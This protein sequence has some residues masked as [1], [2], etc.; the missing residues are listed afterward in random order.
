[1]GLDTAIAT[2]RLASAGIPANMD[3]TVKG[4]AETSGTEA[5][6]IMKLLIIENYKLPEGE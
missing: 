6:E 3:Q 5:I 2:A 1:M 4:I